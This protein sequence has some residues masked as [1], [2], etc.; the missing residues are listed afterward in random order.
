VAKFVEHYNTV[1]L[2]S[3]IGYITPADL[4]ASRCTAIWAETQA[5]RRA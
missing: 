4:L 1:C 3:A 5:R 2:H